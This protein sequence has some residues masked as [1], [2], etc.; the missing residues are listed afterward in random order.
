[1]LCE[2]IIEIIW[3]T[4]YIIFLQ[5]YTVQQHTRGLLNLNSFKLKLVK[6]HFS[7]VIL[8][9]LQVLSNHMCLVATS[10]EAC[11][12][13]CFSRVWLFA[14]QWTIIHQAPLSM[15]F[16]RQEHCSG[17]PRPPPGDFRHP[18]IKP[19]SPVTPALH[20]DSLLLSPIRSTD[21]EHL[22][23]HGRLSWTALLQRI[24]Y[25]FWKTVT[26][27]CDWSG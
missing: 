14:T 10:L 7:L 16:S 26:P 1:M 22:H 12:L 19:A 8:V 11:M 24:Y 3:V 9:S 27:G 4:R 15:G 21:T 17:L 23:H 13:S 25:C 5:S 18:G 6:L 2:K 20:A